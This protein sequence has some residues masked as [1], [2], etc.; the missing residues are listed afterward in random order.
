MNRILTVIFL[1]FLSVSLQAQL[2][3]FEALKNG[4]IDDAEIKKELILNGFTKVTASSASS[5]EISIDSYAWGYDDFLEEAALWVTIKTAE[6]DSLRIFIIDVQSFGHENHEYLKDE[7]LQN[8]T[9]EGIGSDDALEYKYESTAM[10]SISSEN[11]TNFISV[12][13]SIETI[14][15]GLETDVLV[16]Q[17]QLELER[18]HIELQNIEI[19]LMKDAGTL[20]SFGQNAF[21]NQG[22]GVT[23]GSMGI[24]QGDGN[25]GDPNGSP[26]ADNYGTGGGLGDGPTF[27][28]LGSRKAVGSLPMPNMSGCEIT[29]KI[30]IKVEIVVDQHG[31]VDSAIVQS[32]SYQDNC[33]WT[34]VVEAAKQSRFSKD[35]NANLKQ[36]GWIKYTIVP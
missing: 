30:E 25:Q 24:T 11:G 36:T 5:N 33:I 23:E 3:T 4:V 6:I 7:I 32:A 12:S 21:G 28:G 22:A 17:R 14:F 27:G 9:F 16:E 31:K 19:D 18:L 26:D 29:Q 10:F 34:G 20:N 1:S 35:R 13:P 2:I 8:C 15:S